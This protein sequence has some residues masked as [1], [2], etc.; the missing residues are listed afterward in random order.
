MISDE[1]AAIILPSVRLDISPIS[2]YYTTSLLTI[3][4]IIRSLKDNFRLPIS[5]V[6]GKIIKHA[7]DSI[8]KVCYII[9]K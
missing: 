5:P 9:L 6:M 7:I 8:L 4:H 3:V 1:F 2:E